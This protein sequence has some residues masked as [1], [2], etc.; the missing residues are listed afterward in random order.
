MIADNINLRDDEPSRAERKY[1][2]RSRRCIANVGRRRDAVAYSDCDRV[3]S[4]RRKLLH[5]LLVAQEA[6]S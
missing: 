4:S 1:G 5:L 3:R 2:T 6:R